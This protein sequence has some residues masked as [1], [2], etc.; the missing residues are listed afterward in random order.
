MYRLSAAYLILFL[1][2]YNSVRATR[3]NETTSC[4]PTDCDRLPLRPLFASSLNIRLG[5]GLRVFAPFVASLS[6]SSH[7]RH[8]RPAADRLRIRLR[9]FASPHH[10]V[11]W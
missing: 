2:S 5:L 10:V 8:T 11:R 3:R 7:P 4:N 9:Q 6:W 1:Y